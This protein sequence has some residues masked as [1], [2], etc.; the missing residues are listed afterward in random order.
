MHTL[1]SFQQS[2]YEKIVRC[3]PQ[4]DE[5]I[6]D[7]G[8]R[9]AN[10]DKLGTKEKIEA[11]MDKLTMQWERLCDNVTAS[12]ESLQQELADWFST[13]YAQ[14]EAYLEKSNQVLQQI[15]KAV[16]VNANYDNTLDAQKLSVNNLIADY[17]AVFSEENSQKFYHLLDKVFERRPPDDLDAVEISDLDFQPLSHEDVT[18]TE[19]MQAAWN[20]N[21]ELAKLY[22]M[23]LRLRVKVLECMAIIY[24]GQ[25]FCSIQFDM[26]LKSLE[27]AHYDYEV[28][29]YVCK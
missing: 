27:T 24:D 26:D 21:W 22:L 28:Y 2:L 19:A 4:Y 9:L 12:I 11:D 17:S 20:E 18:K 5:L 8:Q 16:S 14:L 29:M 13:I 3:T 7:F 15:F 6:N 10:H 25:V 1:L 23:L